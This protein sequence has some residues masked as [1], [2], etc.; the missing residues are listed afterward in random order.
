MAMVV[1]KLII[2]D[3]EGRKVEEEVEN[4]PKKRSTLSFSINCKV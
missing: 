4:A 2:V 1:G 3:E